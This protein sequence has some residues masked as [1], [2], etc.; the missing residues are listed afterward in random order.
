M[1]RLLLIFALALGFVGI[2]A[3][4]SADVEVDVEFSSHVAGLVGGIDRVELRREKYFRQSTV[5]QRTRIRARERLNNGMFSHTEW[6]GE[7][8]IPELENYSMENLIRALVIESL[9]RA[10]I[11][12]DG[13]I[14][15]EL[16]RI[17]VHNHSVRMI[18]NGN[19]YA[20]GR[21]TLIDESGRE[22][23]SSEISANLVL[24]YS[25]Q[26]SYDG[27]DFAF[28]PSDPDNRIGPVLTYFVR[29]SLSAMFPGTEF[30]RAVILAF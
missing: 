30:P 14:R 26:I 13:T 17:K 19:N 21:I 16:D 4:A 22:I 2:P 20:K 25:T 9:E 7:L 11:D 23:R 1:S 12:F 10:G 27:P 3:I 8:L 29:K 28:Y 5:D 15:I 6:A 18:A 24:D